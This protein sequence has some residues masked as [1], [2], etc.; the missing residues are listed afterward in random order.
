MSAVSAQVTGQ[1][2]VIYDDMIRTGGSLI[3]AAASY[4]EAGATRVSAIATHGVFPEGAIAKIRQ[5]GL[6]DQLVVTDSHPRAVAAASD[7]V[8]VVSIAPMVSEHL[9]KSV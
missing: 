5:S 7:F 4:K 6:F 8:K 1:H 2:V 9:R 3:K